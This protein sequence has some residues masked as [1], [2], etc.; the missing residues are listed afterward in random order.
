MRMSLISAAFLS[1]ALLSGCSCN[2][3]P[4]SPGIAAPVWL[5]EGI[6]H[7]KTTI[8]LGQRG[9]RLDAERWVEPV[10]AI[11]R[12]GKSVASAMVFTSLIS[13]DGTVIVDEAATVYESTGED[14]PGL[15]TPGKL[16]PP[17][18]STPHAVRFRIVLPEVEEEW[19][20]EVEVR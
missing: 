14:G 13:A 8:S 7:E 12:D 2:S 4:V 3:Q 17:A 9:E 10:A 18:G 15:Y 19:T 6:E 11:T 20:R 5:E 16:E 1:L